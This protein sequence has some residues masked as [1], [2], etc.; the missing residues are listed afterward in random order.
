[1][2]DDRAHETDDVDGS[3]FV[4]KSPAGK[5]RWDGCAVRLEFH[6][7][8]SPGL[9]TV[10]TVYLSLSFFFLILRP[11]SPPSIVLR[12]KSC[13]KSIARQ[14]PSLPRVRS[15]LSTAIPHSPTRP[16]LDDHRSHKIRN[17][18]TACFNPQPM[19]CCLISS[20]H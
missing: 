17:W 5:A 11:F 20:P 1:M 16:F 18:K 13:A 7:M 15:D 12:P 10:L 8:F 9:H 14:G 6:H 4:S 2:R 3:C 19:A